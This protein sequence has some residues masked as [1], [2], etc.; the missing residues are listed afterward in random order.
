MLQEYETLGHMVRIDSP[1]YERDTFYLP[2]HA[3]LKPDSSST[4]VRVVFNGSSKTSTGY[5]LN[6]VLYQKDQ[7]KY[8]RIVFRKNLR[9][10]LELTT[11]TFGINWAPL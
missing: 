2:H 3:V 9:N 10:E 7:T 11:V 8:Q 4:K 1:S 6:D 5:S